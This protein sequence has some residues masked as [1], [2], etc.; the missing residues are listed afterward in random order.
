MRFDRHLTR[1]GCVKIASMA[2]TSGNPCEHLT[3]LKRCKLKR[4]CIH[5]FLPGM[6]VPTILLCSF[7]KPSDLSPW[8][9]VS[10]STRDD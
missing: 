4:I 5:Y 8:R 2:S 9:A 3:H 1:E 6:S 7:S 10:P